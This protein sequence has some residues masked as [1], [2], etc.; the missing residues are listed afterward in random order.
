MTL[1]PSHPASPYQ[2]TPQSELEI[3]GNFLAHPFSELIAEIAQARLSGSMRVSEKDRKCVIYFKSGLIVF[4]VS[5]ARSSRLFDMLIRRGTLTKAD[6][7][8]NPDFQNDMELASALKYSELLTEQECNALFTQ[9]VVSII[10]DVLTWPAGEWSFSALARIRDG[11]AFMVDT[12][13]MLLDYGR[14]LP[15]NTMLSRFRSLEETFTRT[16][17]SEM[18]V[19]LTPDEAFVLSRTG[20]GSCTAS[21]LAS[22]SAMAEAEAL[23]VLYSLWLAG[24]LT[25][26]DW[27]AAFSQ[28]VVAQMK[29]AKL[30]LRQEAKYPIAPVNV[31]DEKR[32]KAPVAVRAEP[33]KAPEIEMTLEEYLERVERS[34]TH[35]DLLGVDTK[36]EIPELKAAYFAL[37]KVFH[38]D[39]YHAEG[40][41]TLRRVQD[42][43]TKLAQAHETLKHSESRL[44]YDYRMRKELTDKEKRG[45]AGSA[46]GHNLRLE[47]AIENFDRGFNLLV[48]GNAEAATPFLARAVHFA[49]N[50]ARYHAYYG[51]A[52][53]A[54][55]E[56]RH[57]AET[58]MQQALKIDPNNPTFRILLAEFFIQFNLLK[59]AEGELT[60]LLKVFPSN[61]EARDMLDRLQKQL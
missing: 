34:E 26:T 45:A 6:I 32:K 36:V 60:R 1:R 47:Q 54:D 9:Q 30:E 3:K 29:N 21:T 53:A 37:A 24:L 14:C 41:E 39:R 12:R 56:Q 44:V 27:Q 23:H 46:G 19:G 55:K 57:K 43:F 49:P 28:S 7:T 8:K 52:L 61:R 17:R 51:K 4:A 5:N 2:M 25:R 31:V 16:D 59:R 22:V 33:E 42:A 48:E 40:G 10:R 18:G 50:N 20:D 11:L 38:P 58:E 35:Y 15:M 13:Q